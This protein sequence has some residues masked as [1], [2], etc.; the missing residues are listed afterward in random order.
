[1]NA[2]CTYVLFLS[3]SLSSHGFF[4]FFSSRFLY[5][6]IF[7]CEV[8]LCMKLVSVLQCCWHGETEE[9]T[10]ELYSVRPTLQDSNTN[11]CIHTHKIERKR[12]LLSLLA[13]NPDHVSYGAG[14]W[15]LL[16]TK[17]AVLFSTFKTPITCDQAF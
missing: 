5:L 8:T 9:K 11:T 16:Y 10:I 12:D 6:S 4:L 13:A 17:I 2:S 14:G 3:L 15:D 7:L 1:M